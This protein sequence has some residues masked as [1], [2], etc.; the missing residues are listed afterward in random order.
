MLTGTSTRTERTIP[1]KAKQRGDVLY[2]ATLFFVSRW[3]TMNSNFSQPQPP[4]STIPP[5]TSGGCAASTH[6]CICS[7]SLSRSNGRSFSGLSI[8][9]FLP[10]FFCKSN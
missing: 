8:H 6:S 7:L 5:S 1:I 9:V 2:V 4:L 3:E 10:F